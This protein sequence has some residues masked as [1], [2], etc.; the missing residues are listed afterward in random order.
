MSRPTRGGKTDVTDR[1]N[2]AD[3][4]WERVPAGA[5]YHNS[6]DEMTYKGDMLY[7]LLVNMV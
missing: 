5:P 3:G 6:M 2:S 7:W 1:D 4:T